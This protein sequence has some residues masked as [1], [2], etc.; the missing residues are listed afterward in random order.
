[1]LEATEILR[2]YLQGLRTQTGARCV[3]LFAPADS[4]SRALL[5]HEGQ[6]PAVPELVSLEAAQS[7]ELERQSVTAEQTWIRSSQEDAFLFRLGPDALLEASVNPE[8]RSPRD[9]R[10]RRQSDTGTTRPA[11]APIAAW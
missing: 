8:V 2:L 4:P 7:F 10:R 5:L 3:S 6:R 1:M 9:A 11:A